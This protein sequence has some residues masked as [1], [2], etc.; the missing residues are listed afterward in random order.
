[1]FLLPFE[2]LIATG[3][4]AAPAWGKSFLSFVLGTCPP[5]QTLVKTNRRI[6]S[7]RNMIAEVEFEEVPGLLALHLGN[8]HK[9]I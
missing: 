1:M 4:N 9:F 7:V 8:K 2:N 5:N 3:R 6:T